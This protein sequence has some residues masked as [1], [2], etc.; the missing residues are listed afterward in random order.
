MSRSYANRRRR[1]ARSACSFQRRDG[2][3][4]SAGRGRW[5]KA[6]GGAGTVCRSVPLLFLE[7][8]LFADTKPGF[9]PPCAVGQDRYAGGGFV[10]Q[11]ATCEE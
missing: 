3:G 11:H 6:E 9:L 4:D 5:A 8:W 1:K 7:R 10:A 2:A